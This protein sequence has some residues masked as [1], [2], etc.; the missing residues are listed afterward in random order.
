MLQSRASDGYFKG[1]ILLWIIGNK[2]LTRCPAPCDQTHWQRG[3]SR[4]YGEYDTL[5]AN[6]IVFLNF[7]EIAYTDRGVYSLEVQHQSSTCKRLETNIT[8]YIHVSVPDPVCATTYMMEN[9]NV[10]FTC[11]WNLT[12]EYKA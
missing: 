5:S 8:V 6:Q 12:F 10:R 3:N 1:S 2:E 7:T 4:A 11:K 9:N